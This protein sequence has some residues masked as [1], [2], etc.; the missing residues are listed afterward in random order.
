[1]ELMDI[2]DATSEIKGVNRIFLIISPYVV[3]FLGTMLLLFTIGTVS[4]EWFDSI[5]SNLA[6]LG[7]GFSL[8]CLIF[9]G[10]HISGAHYNPAVTIGVLLT[11]RSVLGPLKSLGYVGMQLLGGTVGAIIANLCT[12]GTFGPR[13]GLNNTI[14]EAFAVELIATFMLLTVVLN[15]AH[16][17]A[18]D[19]NSYYGLAIG[20]T[21]C[22]MAI[23]VGP[24]SGGAFNPAVGTAAMVATLI[25]NGNFSQHFWIYWA[26]PLTG[27]ALAAGLFRV[28]NV[29]E[30]VGTHRQEIKR[31]SYDVISVIKT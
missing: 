30:Y 18:N 2:V 13:V 20:L 9:F 19:N 11:R 4:V 12:K 28:T 22:S 3:E 5:S 15:V 1:M 7:I 29:R 17:I 8:V 24:I 25:H 16:T 27:A 14:A 10:G 21:V 31:K 26:G 23:A 6:P